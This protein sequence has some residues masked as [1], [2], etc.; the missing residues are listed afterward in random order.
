MWF[1]EL[2]CHVALLFVRYGWNHAPDT[3]QIKLL[4]FS[5][6]IIMIASRGA[7]VAAVVEF[8]HWHWTMFPV[9]VK[10]GKRKPAGPLREAWLKLSPKR[11]EERQQAGQL[12]AYC[13]PEFSQGE[14]GWDASQEDFFCAFIIYLPVDT[15]K[16]AFICFVQW[17]ERLQA[18][19]ICWRKSKSKT[20]LQVRKRMTIEL[21]CTINLTGRWL[22]YTGDSL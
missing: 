16:I 21:R 8:I 6:F 15:F 10:E 4:F 11:P 20:T 18:Y 2:S 19:C 1:W 5:F 22:T 12:Q 13:C 14:L 3:A 7:D 9:S 17:P